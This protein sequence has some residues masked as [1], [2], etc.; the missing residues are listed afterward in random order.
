MKQNGS[1]KKYT[2]LT[3]SLLLSATV[4]VAPAFASETNQTQNVKLQNTSQYLLA[5]IPNSCRQVIASSGL[6]VRQEANSNSQA[7]GIIGSGRTVT[8]QSLGEN[9]WVPITAPLKGYVYG[10]FLGECETA[11]SPPPTDCRLVAAVRGINV[12]QTPSSEGETAGF[13]ANG[14]RVTIESLGSDGWVPITVPLK[15]YV[16]SENLAYCR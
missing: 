16:Q 10:G 6:N 11:N 5:Q 1:W 13:I 2:S 12:H 4:L 14:R 15:G 8:I 7:V 3:S 9:G